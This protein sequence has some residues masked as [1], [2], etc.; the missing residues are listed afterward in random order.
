MTPLRRPW[1]WQDP[2]GDDRERPYYGHRIAAEARDLVSCIRRA[3]P[4]VNSFAR[5]TSEGNLLALN[6]TVKPV[7][8]VAD[9]ILDAS[10]GGVRVLDPFLAS[11]T[12][13]I[14]AQ[15]TGR[16]GYGFKLDPRYVATAIRRWQRLTGK[17]AIHLDSGATFDQV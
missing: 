9:A 8:L 1:F 12:T 15:R 16:I 3:Q 11:G 10:R 2:R 4:G 13:L 14:A 7:A 17:K 6:P 5:E